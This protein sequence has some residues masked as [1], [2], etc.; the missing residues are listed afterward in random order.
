MVQHPEILKKAQAEV[1]R[2]VGTHRLPDMHDKTS[3]PYIE[4]IIQEC[5]RWQPVLPVAIPHQLTQDD[6]YRGYF[7]PEGSLIFA[8]AWSIL[9]DEK[10][11]PNPNAFN[12]ERFLKDG[13]LNPDVRDPGVACF[14]FG[15]RICP[16]R[17]MAKESLYIIIS[18][19]VA[20][21]DFTKAVGPDGVPITPKTNYTTDLLNHPKPFLCSIKP[22]SEERALQVSATANDL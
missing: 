12:P 18:S 10:A 21:F 22:R 20:A 3:L 16:G 19:L 11:Y 2:V 8:N 13:V 14:G 5:L 9:H 15:R 6:E 4:A 17:F 1:D 7:I